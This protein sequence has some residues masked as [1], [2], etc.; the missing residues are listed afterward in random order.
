MDEPGSTAIAVTF[1]DRQDVAV[2]LGMLEEAIVATASSEGAV[3]DV[4]VTLVDLDE[5]ARLN[6]EHLG[7][8]GPTDVL[9]FPV[10]GLVTEAGEVP[11]M[12]GEIVICPAYAM[13]AE[14]LSSELKLLAVHG[15]LHLLGFD[16]DSDEAA[17]EMR[18]KEMRFAGR[19][20]AQS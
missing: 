18:L 14:E 19:A 2:D 9:A 16:H 1:S 7:A 15:T 20:G 8:D 10:D 17:A 12:I 11:V 3:G 6:K 4:S 13:S 5:M